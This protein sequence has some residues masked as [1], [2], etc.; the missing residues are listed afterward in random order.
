[1]AATSHLNLRRPEGKTAFGL[2]QPPP[3]TMHVARPK[4]AKG[5]TR[6]SVTYSRGAEACSSCPV[7]SSPQPLL[8]PCEDVV[9]GR[10]AS[11]SQPGQAFEIRDPLQPV[12]LRTSSSLNKYRVLPS[13]SRKELRKNAVERTPEW[14]GQQQA[15]TPLVEEEAQGSRDL[16]GGGKV[17]TP[18]LA[19]HKGGAGEFALTPP[20]PPPTEI[21]P[22]SETREGASLPPATDWEEPCEEEEPRLLLAI[23]SPSGQRFEHHFRPADRLEAV[24]AAAERH[25][26]ATYRHCSIETVG[27][28]RRTFSDLSKSL[29]ECA[30]P[31]KSVLCI[32]REQPEGEP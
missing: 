31:H 3:L 11:S 25:N 24:L 26:S 13:I 1:M 6:S 30:I 23:R 7:P 8:A 10:R 2:A 15:S 22:F 14:A 5:R 12:P 20:P 21:K 16:P 4:S 27:V 29:Q 17:P 28:P 9:G 32:L 19:R 18:L